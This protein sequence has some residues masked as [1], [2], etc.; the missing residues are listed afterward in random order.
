MLAGRSAAV[1][2]VFHVALDHAKAESLIADQA[3]KLLFYVAQK[4]FQYLRKLKTNAL[5]S[6]S[7]VSTSLDREEAEEVEFQVENKSSVVDISSGSAGSTEDRLSVCHRFISWSIFAGIWLGFIAS[8]ILTFV[9]IWTPYRNCLTIGVILAIVCLGVA[10][11]N[12]LRHGDTAPAVLL[13][14]RRNSQLSLSCELEVAV[15]AEEI[16]EGDGEGEVCSRSVSLN[17][18]RSMLNEDE[19][20]VPVCTGDQCHPHND[21]EAARIHI[22]PRKVRRD[23]AFHSL[24]RAIIST[25]TRAGRGGGAGSGG[26]GVGGGGGFYPDPRNPWNS[27]FE[28]HIGWQSAMARPDPFYSNSYYQ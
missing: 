26:G 12:C 24:T 15:E 7:T 14:E 11:H 27:N 25:L 20:G 3:A 4:Q 18:N 2:D 21:V 10:V 28:G 22:H 23:S 16:P 5:L 8:I 19:N 17:E 1:K 9:G 6:S 13:Y